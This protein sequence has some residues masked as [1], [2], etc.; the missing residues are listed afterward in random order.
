M[1]NNKTIRLY[2]YCIS[3]LYRG[4][5]LDESILE[6][7]FKMKNETLWISYNEATCK[8]K[9]QLFRTVLQATDYDD[10]W[11]P[12]VRLSNRKMKQGWFA[13]QTSKHFI[14]EHSRI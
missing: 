11:E 10:W 1:E 4:L 8:K 12:I 2:V 6:E 5:P 13:I 3:I 9:T 7:T 14:A